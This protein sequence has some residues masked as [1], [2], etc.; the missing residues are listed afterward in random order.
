[1][2]L[3]YRSGDGG[4]K[5]SIRRVR[6]RAVSLELSDEEMT[7]LLPL[8][9][10]IGEHIRR[11]QQSRD[12]K[13]RVPDQLSDEMKAR[14]DAV[15]SQRGLAAGHVGWSCDGSRVKVWISRMEDSA[16]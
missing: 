13:N 2:G 3:A 6:P 11:A 16:T 12:L 10:R 15:V 4:G 7:S 14:L 8:A 5:V 1:M 9:L